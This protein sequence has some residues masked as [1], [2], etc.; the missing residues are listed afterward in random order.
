[1]NKEKIIKILGVDPGIA[2]TGYGIISKNQ[3]SNKVSLIN[4]GYI[5]TFSN[6]SFVERLEKIYQELNKIIK[7]YKP[8]IIAVEKIFFCKNVKT[9]LHV[10]QA[11]G[12]ILL[13]AIQNKIPLFEFT[14]LEIKQA[15]TSYGQADKKQIQ[16]MVQFLLKLKSLPQPDD[17]AD[18]LACALTCLNSMKIKNYGK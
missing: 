1:M 3:I 7:K 8:T 6:Q 2:T 14:P 13:T 12:V 5:S 15:I 17:A 9:A 18:A 4:F 16:K 10:G 11:R